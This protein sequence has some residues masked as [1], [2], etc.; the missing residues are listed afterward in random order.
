[1]KRGAHKHRRR[2]MSISKRTDRGAVI[3]PRRFPPRWSVEEQRACFVVRDHNGQ[4]LAYVHFEHE[5]GPEIGGKIIGTR[6]GEMNCRKCRRS[7]FDGRP[8][9]RY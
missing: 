8:S 4:A 1:M 7:R 2:R 3:G 9:S 5:P 6:R